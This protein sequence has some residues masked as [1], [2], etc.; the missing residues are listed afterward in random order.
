MSDKYLNKYLH[1]HSDYLMTTLI[2][3]YYLEIK[4][5]RCRELLSRGFLIV[6]FVTQK[7]GTQ[8]LNQAKFYRI[9]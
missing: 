1:F 5:K 2:K 8:E 9:K 7:R 6:I 3:K 4:N